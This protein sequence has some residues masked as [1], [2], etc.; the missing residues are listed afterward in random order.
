MN[1][2]GGHFFRC[3]YWCWCCCC[4]CVS[5]FFG[6]GI[7]WHCFCMHFYS[8]WKRAHTHS[9]SGQRNLVSVDWYSCFW[10]LQLR[11]CWFR[12]RLCFLFFC[13]FVRCRCI[14]CPCLASHRIKC[15]ESNYKRRIFW[16]NNFWHFGLLYACTNCSYYATDEMLFNMISFQMNFNENDYTWNIGAHRNESYW[17][18]GKNTHNN[19]SSQR[20][21]MSVEHFLGKLKYLAGD[22]VVLIFWK[23]NFIIKY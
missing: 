10:L 7:L 15:I 14:G 6:D 12:L 2:F 18:N 13:F 9:N 17:K 3:W 19:N 22:F 23:E 5:W 20:Q 21:D 1:F 11:F 16:Y 8:M 4:C